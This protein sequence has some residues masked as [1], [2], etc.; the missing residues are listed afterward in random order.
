[1]AKWSD[2][3]YTKAAPKGGR[4]SGP[5]VAAAL[6]AEAKARQDD[7]DLRRGGSTRQARKQE[8]NQQAWKRF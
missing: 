2:S 7:R 1:M 3:W 8:Y 6:R 5:A 4:L